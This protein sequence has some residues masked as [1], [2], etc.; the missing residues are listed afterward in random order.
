LL[1]QATTHRSYGTSNNE[2]LE[3]LGDS[4]LNCVIAQMLFKRFS[5]LNEGE[6]SRLRSNLVNQDRLFAIANKLSLGQYLKMGIGE[7]KSN[8]H[9][10]PSILSDAVEAVFGAVFLDGGFE[11]TSFV[12]KN[13]YDPIISDSNRDIFFKK[14]SKTA[15]QEKLQG[16][17]LNPPHY[18]VDKVEGFAHQQTFKVVC[19]IPE[20]NIISSG[21]GA[22]RRAAEKDAARLA[23]EI[24]GE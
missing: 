23:L 12:I 2:R 10:K 17:G 16:K 14:D 21:E 7:K 8:G 20:M 24:V 11:A 19:K 4:I 1:E 3:F 18:T 22:S 15:L 5:P 6:L 13:L 9:A